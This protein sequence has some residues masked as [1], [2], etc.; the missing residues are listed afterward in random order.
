MVGFFPSMYSKGSTAGASATR[1]DSWCNIN[2]NNIYILVKA[3]PLVKMR[4]YMT[5]SSC[6]YNKK[7][8]LYFSNTF[9]VICYSF[10]AI[11]TAA[12]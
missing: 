6:T 11:T 4:Y 10:S 3:R 5:L 9:N 8:L 2:I 12:V 1:G 7:S